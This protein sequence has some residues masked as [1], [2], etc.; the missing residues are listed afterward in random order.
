M[1]YRELIV[2]AAVLCLGSEVSAQTDTPAV[3]PPNGAVGK[4]EPFVPLTRNKR[5][6]IDLT[7]IQ[8]G[9]FYYDDTGT[10]D[11][12]EVDLF[13]NGKL[14]IALQL[15]GLD[16]GYRLPNNS[17]RLGVNAGSGGSTATIGEY[18][19]SQDSSGAC[20]ETVRQESGMVLVLNA[21]LFIQFRDLMRF[22]VG[23]MRGLSGIETARGSQR[24]DSARYFGITLNT[25]IGDLLENVIRGK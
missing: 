23:A 9:S 4:T 22:E 20:T 16:L 2:A 25:K 5:F 10:D 1:R 13:E 18:C 19:R 14:A 15:A 3:A 6:G 11:T 7:L 8:P 12:G 21:G 24:T 17:V